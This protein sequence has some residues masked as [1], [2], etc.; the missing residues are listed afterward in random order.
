[1]LVEIIPQQV[2]A[3]FGIHFCHLKDK[4]KKT[5]SHL[6][7]AEQV[8]YIKSVELYYWKQ[9][10]PRNDP[11]TAA[12]MKYNSKDAAGQLVKQGLNSTILLLLNDIFS[13]SSSVI[14]WNYNKA[15]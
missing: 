14:V 13:S 9:L 15:L 2:A 3:V 4:K 12:Q 11:M 8:V 1:M 5:S 7:S 10:L 6:P